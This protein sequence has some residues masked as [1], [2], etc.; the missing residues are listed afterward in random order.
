MTNLNRDTG[1]ATVFIKQWNTCNRFESKSLIPRET[2]AQH[3]CS[4]LRNKRSRV[5]SLPFL[6]FFFT[7]T[8]F[9]INTYNEPT[10]NEWTS[11]KVKFKE[12]CQSVL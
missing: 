5:Y 3:G 9:I 7:T 10:Q 8:E 11:T 2:Y 4:L 12:K 1:L 6:L